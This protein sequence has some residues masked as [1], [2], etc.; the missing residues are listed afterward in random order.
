[1]KVVGKTWILMLLTLTGIVST[2][3]VAADGIGGSGITSAPT[4]RFG[5]IVID[6]IHYETDQA[7]I[8][9]NGEPAHEH[10]LKVGYRV[11]IG[12]DLNTAVAETVDYFDSVAGPLESV[13]IDDQVMGEATLMV[14]GQRVVTDAQTWLHDI[15]LNALTVGQHLVVS[16]SNLPDGT[17]KADALVAMSRHQQ[18]VTGVV[19]NSD[20]GTFNIGALVIDASNVEA[21][22]NNPAGEDVR[23]GDRLHVVGYYQG[24]GALHATRLYAAF[25]SDGSAK[26]AR[27]QGPLSHD[28]QRWILE[29]F[30]LEISDQ[31]S[32]LTGKSEDLEPGVQVSVR[33]TLTADGILR[34]LEMEV[35]RDALSQMAGAIT[36]V[37]KYT[38]TV[39]INDIQVKVGEQLSMLD[40]RDGYRWFAPEDL[41]AYDNVKLVVV[42]RGGEVVAKRVLRKHTLR[43][44]VRS[45]VENAGWSFTGIRSLTRR[46]DDLVD[47]RE[48][49][50]NGLQIPSWMIK[51]YVQDGDDLHVEWDDDGAIDR[52]SIIT[53]TIAQ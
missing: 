40:S 45:R 21:E 17:I 24:N 34:A 1:M 9:I 20:D 23:D 11:L 53:R 14:M 25:K 12:G 39:M 28:G 31:T 35:E 46:F 48:A 3:E 37:D 10:D 32:Y 27:V 16:G 5:S 43:H 49:R 42:Q 41:A 51:Y 2:S 8:R 38:G 36:A 33:G 18:V 44:S 52:V 15:E 22:G 26:P 29:G 19:A 4:Q 50:I 7:Q 13:S 47:A 6:G 30:P